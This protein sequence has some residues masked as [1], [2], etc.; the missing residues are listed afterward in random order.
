MSKTHCDN[1]SWINN[2]C[3]II[4]NLMKNRLT[5]HSSNKHKSIIV[6]KIENRLSLNYSDIAVGLSQIPVR[7]SLSI[8]LY[9]SHWLCAPLLISYIFQIIIILSSW[10]LAS[11]LFLTLKFHYSTSFKVSSSLLLARTPPPPRFLANWWQWLLENRPA[12]KGRSIR[13]SVKIL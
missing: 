9:A 1:S 3:D 8:I 11:Q 5:V 7:I 13:A 6:V 10:H 4:I 2:E 12:G